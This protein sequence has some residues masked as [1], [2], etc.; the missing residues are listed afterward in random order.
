MNL[1]FIFVPFTLVFTT[2]SDTLDSNSNITLRDSKF[3]RWNTVGV[4]PDMISCCAH[5]LIVD[6]SDHKDYDNL[7]RISLVQ[8]YNNSVTVR[9]FDQTMSFH[10]SEAA[11]SRMDS[12]KYGLEAMITFNREEMKIDHF[13]DF[14]ALFT[15]FDDSKLVR[16]R[17]SRCKCGSKFH[18]WPPILSQNSEYVKENLLV[19]VPDFSFFTDFKHPGNHGGTEDIWFPL[20][21]DEA[22]HGYDYR[23][24]YRAIKYDEKPFDYAVWRGKVSKRQWGH[25]RKSV[26]NCHRLG[27]INS[28][29]RKPIPRQD[30]CSQYKLI[31][32]L[33]GNGVWSWAT[34]FNLVRYIM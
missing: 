4:T 32:T 7:R 29:E 23:S 3:I 12:M 1:I 6:E 5:R 9:T 22:L 11:P 2:S 10:S 20:M 27:L 17:N 25:V 14:S 16:S 8:V 30:M 33:P 31:L 26:A 13:P 19:T 21:K 28:E 15:V 18:D 34:K 24:R